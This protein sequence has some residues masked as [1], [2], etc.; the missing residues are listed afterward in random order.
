MK[1]ATSRRRRFKLRFLGMS[2]LI[3]WF[4][5]TLSNHAGLLNQTVNLSP[6]DAASLEQAKTPLVSRVAQRLLRLVKKNQPK[7]A[8]EASNPLRGAPHQRSVP[9]LL[10]PDDEGGL[11][12]GNDDTR[13]LESIAETFQSIPSR[14]T[15]REQTLAYPHQIPHCVIEFA[16]RLNHQVEAGLQ[17]EG[18]ALELASALSTYAVQEGDHTVSSLQALAMKK[19]LTLQKAYPHSESLAAVA[20]DTEHRL[21]PAIRYLLKERTTKATSEQ[22]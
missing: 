2:L 22:P 14:T 3:S 4:G 9:A 10:T 18:W 13:P 7:A 11:P 16:I 20:S 15:L 19:L 21:K 12:P 1:Q 8:T 17:S 6:G 5:L